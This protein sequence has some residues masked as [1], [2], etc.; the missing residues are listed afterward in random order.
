MKYF[1]IIC[2]PRTGST[3]LAK[4][5]DSY[6]YSGE[7]WSHPNH[8]DWN[9]ADSR[10]KPVEFFHEFAKLKLI[11]PKRGVRIHT[12]H[13]RDMKEQSGAYEKLLNIFSSVVLLRRKNLTEQAIS[14]ILL[15]KS[16]N[17]KKSPLKIDIQ[18]CISKAEYFYNSYIEWSSRI[19]KE[20]NV[21]KLWYEDLDDNMLNKF[22]E[23][24]SFLDLPTIDDV[25]VDMKKN[26][27]FRLYKNLIKNYD[28]LVREMGPAYGVPFESPASK[29][30]EI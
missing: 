29:W 19:P 8:I 13:L 30:G 1:A 14:Y 9:L 2:N 3:L 4:S 20:C 27:S 28:D 11:D 22:N 10:S 5:L 12:E 23:V 17:E 16:I 24:R 18:D 6:C 21:Y 26:R 7:P 15:F 25:N